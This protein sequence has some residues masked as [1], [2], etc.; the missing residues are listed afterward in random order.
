MLRECHHLN[1]EDEFSQMLQSTSISRSWF[2]VLPEVQ[3]GSATR[4]STG[5]YN[6]SVQN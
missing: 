5:C 3:F 1:E 6:R 2:V 4:Y